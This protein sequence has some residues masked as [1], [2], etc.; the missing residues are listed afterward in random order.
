MGKFTNGYSSSFSRSIARMLYLN[1]DDS[2]KYKTDLSNVSMALG[3]V[4]IEKGDYETA[5]NDF[6]ECLKYRT[7]CYPM[8]SREIA[9]VLYL[10]GVSQLSLAQTN[11]LS[12]EDDASLVTKAE[13]N[14]KD[15]CETFKKTKVTLCHVCLDLALKEKII[16]KKGIMLIITSNDRG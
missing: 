13:E 6:Q 4:N 10:L 15:A 16:E 3:E 5:V 2:N 9:D 1:S 11:A 7:E 14:A 12:S 8:Y